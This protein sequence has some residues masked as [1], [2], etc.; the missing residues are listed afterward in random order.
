MCVGWK[1]MYRAVVCG[2]G[3]M[4]VAWWCVCDTTGHWQHKLLL[5]M[6][7][8]RGWGILSLSAVWDDTCLTPWYTV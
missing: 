1:C 2:G 5:L 8:W 7:L 4:C 6:T 3:G